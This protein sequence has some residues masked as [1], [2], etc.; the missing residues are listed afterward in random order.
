MTQSC[1]VCKSTSLTPV[2]E[3]GSM[4]PANSLA[5]TID[6]DDQH[7][8]YPLNLMFCEGCS[9]LQLQDFTTSEDLFM[10]D[11]PYFSSTSTSFLEH[12]QRYVNDMVDSHNITTE[13][14][15]IEIASNDG[16]L[17]KNFVQKGIPC[18]GIE[19]THS[20]AK[21]ARNLGITTY[22]EFFSEEYAYTFK[23]SHGEVDLCIANNV[24]AHVPDPVDFLK[25]IAVL[26]RKNAFATLEFPYALNLL[27]RNQFD[28]VYHEHFSY[29]T[30]SSLT[31]ALKA[32]GLKLFKIDEISTHG[33]SLRCYVS[34]EKSNHK[35][36]ENVG[37][38]LKLEH[39]L[40]V[41]DLAYYAKLGMNT[42]KIINR[43]KDF[44]DEEFRCSRSVYG[45]GAA[46][47]A[48]TLINSARLRNDRI[49]GIFDAAIAKQN[50]FTPQ[51]NIPI[52][53]PE[54]MSDLRID[55]LVIFPWN[56][57]SEIVSTIALNNISVGRIW[58]IKN[59][60]LR[61]ITSDREN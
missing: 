8:A 40:R 15:V 56:I 44:L 25:G 45:Y 59:G 57:E 28:T 13:S 12:A 20:T 27:E 48:I 49:F 17:L 35:V 33:G 61:E 37:K 16:Y 53:S 30:L 42:A 29:W 9:L 51:S 47:K 52:L 21:A 36:D 34:L 55:N 41:T 24:L 11:Y 23:E 50:K 38:Q 32:A 1:R 4:P 10:D 22:E 58:S 5:R 3:L 19:P 6:P 14:K 60:N 31:H 39:T 26:L 2:L 54:K 18:V 46:A 43:F 7:K